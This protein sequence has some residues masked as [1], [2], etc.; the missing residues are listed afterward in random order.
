[1]VEAEQLTSDR[2]GTNCLYPQLSA[3]TS[4]ITKS[5]PLVKDVGTQSASLS[6]D[7]FQLHLSDLAEPR[8]NTSR[9]S[10]PYVAASVER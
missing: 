5:F 1:M 10:K 8:L 2:G 7:H 9:A 3:I 6:P 4:T